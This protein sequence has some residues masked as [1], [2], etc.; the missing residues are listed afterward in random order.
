M[1]ASAAC[2]CLNIRIHYHRDLD[3]Q[4]S[5]THQA[6]SRV[7]LS[8]DPNAVSVSLPPLAGRE[9][10]MLPEAK[11]SFA[12]P[13]L[14]C[15]HCGTT[16]Y[17]VE[18]PASSGPTR[19]VGFQPNGSTNKSAAETSL[20]SHAVRHV[21][22]EASSSP[23]DSHLGKDVAVIRPHDGYI[24]LLPGLLDGEKIA[25]VQH[26]STF[27]PV[28]SVSILSTNLNG[29]ESESAEEVHD[30]FLCPRFSQQRHRTSIGQFSILSQ[31]GLQ[32]LPTHLVSS[33]LGSSP[34]SPTG[35]PQTA[36]TD[37]SL[38]TRAI[39]P[40]DPVAA[41]L[42][43]A[44][45]D[46]LKQ[47]RLAAEQKI[48][49]LVRE[50]S[51]EL[52]LMIQ[53]AKADAEAILERSKS[54]PAPAPRGRLSQTSAAVGSFKDSFVSIPHRT[55]TSDR[56]LSSA[57]ISST[58]TDD[59][60]LSTLSDSAFQ[61]KILLTAPRTSNAPSGQP[62]LSSSLSALSASFATRGNTSGGISTEKWAQKRRVRERYPE[63][64][65]SVM[66][67][68]TTSAA[69]SDLEDAGPDSEEEIV[70]RRGRERCVR[71]VESAASVV[72]SPGPVASHTAKTVSNLG[73]ISKA[74]G[75]RVRS[76]MAPS[77]FSAPNKALASTSLDDGKNTDADTPRPGGRMDLPPS[78]SADVYLWPRDPPPNGAEPLKPATRK[79]VAKSRTSASRSIEA[80]K[81][82]FA[83][84]PDQGQAA[85][86]ENDYSDDGDHAESHEPETAMF[87]IDVE[88][89][90]QGDQGQDLSGKS[91]TLRTAALHG[92]ET[93]VTDANAEAMEFS[94]TAFD[95][96]REIADELGGIR[97]SIGAQ[98]AGSLSAL[99]ASLLAFQAQRKDSSQQLSAEPSGLASLRRHDRVLSESQRAVSETRAEMR[100][101]D[102]LTAQLSSDY[103]A[104][105]MSS[106]PNF[107]KKANHDWG[108][109]AAIGYRTIGDVEMRLSGL[110]APHAPSHRA[111]WSGP[112]SRSKIAKY[113]IEEDTES[114]ESG[115]A[116]RLKGKFETDDEPQWSAWQQRAKNLEDGKAN[117]Q[118][119]AAKNN[120]IAQSLPG[121]RQRGFSANIGIPM[122][123][124]KAPS[125]TMYDESF[126][127]D[128][129]PKT[130]LPYQE[131]KMVPS[132]RKAIR[133]GLT[134][135]KQPLRTPSLPTIADEVEAGEGEDAA[136]DAKSRQTAGAIVIAAQLEQAAAF[137]SL[138]QGLPANSAAS[139][140]PGCLVTRGFPLPYE[141]IQ[142]AVE[143]P[144]A[145]FNRPPTASLTS[146][147]QAPEGSALSSNLS[148]GLGTASSGRSGFEAHATGTPCGRR[149]PRP[150]YV[151]PP[152][153]TSASTV[154]Q[155]HPGHRPAALQLFK[156]P[157][158]PRFAYNEEGEEEET[159]WPKVLSF[160]HRVEKLKINKRTG[161]LHHRIPRAESIADHMY[162][163][164]ML[165]MLCPNDVDI[166]KAVMLALVHDLAEAEVGD[167]TP[168]D[169]VP[170]E[171]KA[172]REAEAVAYLVHDLLGSSP[173]ALRIEALWREYE[174]RQTLES[175]L[176]KDLDRFELLLQA[177]EYERAHDIVDLQPFFSC[178]GDIRHP[179]VR[180]WTVELAK[181]RAMLW[182]E[183]GPEW[184]YE[185]ELPGEEEVRGSAKASI[186]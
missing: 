114:E 86:R 128:R 69:N 186:A 155:P 175:Q 40:Q 56:Y 92:T 109:R 47:W 102:E 166:G 145:Y 96:D 120:T 133:R 160:M 181:E 19:A 179:R 51:K 149:S 76:V 36:T 119:Q 130:S 152:P 75:T 1:P 170:K 101:G 178:V 159:D 25:E 61:R 146:A 66:T 151:P 125:S 103:D 79:G 107:R 139:A 35:I 12:I 52:D 157:P 18:R 163:M 22:S 64:D 46:R 2:P 129:E 3:I 185:Q 6:A 169:K 111:L 38:L 184:A 110:L 93:A 83:E 164:A 121:A 162:R 42:D 99:A 54:V 34:F 10:L 50:K 176:V 106:S 59:E 174:D 150:P 148:S 14:R 15:L 118:K 65:H 84:T 53:R 112:G 45:I 49:E 144:G 137:P 142:G 32:G 117:S 165:A 127:F 158:E 13:A 48:V 80:K 5:G 33:P 113:T 105:G 24:F 73:I 9:L 134:S 154:L 21:G 27:S 72:T 171:E 20:A 26:G 168:L 126:G 143:P 123:A 74:P 82:A 63:S 98:H 23:T 67:S 58:T 11:L 44:G 30:L 71:S 60:S 87:D 115:S 135:S 89:Q 138:A 90:D 28:Y 39:G 122:S 183:K 78:T 70:R 140:L 97:A 8:D 95:D 100:N 104:G 88:I 81:V 131:R 91:A 16:V 124:S 17:A 180:K 147:A 161:W 77:S 7:R 136:T 57:L 4:S 172:R 173:A 156:A 153:P 43:V 37:S 177:T 94:S 68:A 55:V 116:G 132:L 85:A 29:A 141:S 108:G 62:S 182:R 167:L 41:Y 31:Y